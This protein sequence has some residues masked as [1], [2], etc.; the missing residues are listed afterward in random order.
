LTRVLRGPDSI[1]SS[2]DIADMVLFDK[3]QFGA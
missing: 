1:S 3:L 2:E